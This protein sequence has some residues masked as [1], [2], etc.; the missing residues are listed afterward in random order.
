[1]MFEFEDACPRCGASR[2]RSWREL[3]E[4]E[5]E[6]VRRLYKPGDAEGERARCSR[7]CVRCWYE[8]RDAR[9]R[10]V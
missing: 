3:S 8:E 10:N 9:P 5:R 6:L 2:L 7:W 4:E 1:M